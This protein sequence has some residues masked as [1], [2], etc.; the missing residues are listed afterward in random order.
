MSWRAVDAVYKYSKAKDS[1]LLVLVTIAYHINKESLETFVSEST[2]AAET[3]K[4][5][6][7]VRRIIQDL[8]RSGELVVG[9][10]KGRGLANRY[11]LPGRKEDTGDPFSEKEDISSGKRGHGAHKKRTSAA[12]KEDTGDPPTVVPYRQPSLPGTTVWPAPKGKE[13][14]ETKRPTRHA[15]AGYPHK[16]EEKRWCEAHR[17]THFAASA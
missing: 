15:C 8:E 14:A 11:R 2:L 4:S 3:G 1:S 16:G 5:A 17:I 9:H 7:Q 12:L 10:S 13:E 6:L